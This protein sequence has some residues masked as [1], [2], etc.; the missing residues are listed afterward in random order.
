MT[1]LFSFQYLF[2]F[3]GWWTRFKKH[4]I[5]WER[6]GIVAFG[7]LSITNSIF[8]TYF[9]LLVDFRAHKGK[10][11]N[12]HRK[13]TKHG[14]GQS[15][16]IYYCLS[17]NIWTHEILKPNFCDKAYNKKKKIAQHKFSPLPLWSRRKLYHL[18]MFSIQ[19]KN[20]ILCL[21]VIRNEYQM[22]RTL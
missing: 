16:P 15:Y 2:W 7:Q 6:Q 1:F 3:Q 5:P 11:Q 19:A 12:E 14:K 10:D 22:K 4:R 21:I 20:V 18:N 17:R 8:C 9:C 13:I